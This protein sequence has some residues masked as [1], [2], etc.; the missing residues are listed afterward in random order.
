MISSESHQLVGD[1][2]VV[3]ARHSLSDGRLHESRQRRQHVDRGINLCTTNHT[4]FFDTFTRSVRYRSPCEWAVTIE[5]I[6]VRVNGESKITA[7]ML[8]SQPVIQTL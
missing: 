6:H 7:T 1:V 3:L 2:R 5:T 8:I 4:R